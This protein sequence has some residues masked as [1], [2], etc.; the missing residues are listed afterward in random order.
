VIIALD[1]TTILHYFRQFAT[2]LLKLNHGRIWRKC[3]V[4]GSQGPK[5]ED[6]QKMKKKTQVFIQSTSVPNFN[7]IRPFFTSLVC[8]KV[9]VRT[10]TFVRL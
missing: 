9:L 8:P 6:F 10:Y 7:M 1:S 4:K 5:K 3:A 2:E